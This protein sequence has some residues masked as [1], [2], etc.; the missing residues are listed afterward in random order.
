MM[1]A[2]RQK[3]PP[4]DAR[5]M[6]PWRRSVYI[7]S[8]WPGLSPQVGYIRLAVVYDV[9]KS[10]EPDFRCHPRLYLLL[11]CELKTWMPGTRPGMTARGTAFQPS[12]PGLSRP[13]TS[14]LLLPRE[15]K[16]W[17]PGTRPGMTARG[18]A[19]QSS[20]PGL[21]RPSMSLLAAVPPRRGCAQHRRAKARRP[22][23]G[24]V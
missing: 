18:T 15:L 20:W 16:T 10:G 23:D 22:L 1:K 21:S 11:P 5:R 3:P 4:V 19:F 12:W 13:S 24:Y 8:S 7:Q 6:C 17:M 2:S 14:L 9:R